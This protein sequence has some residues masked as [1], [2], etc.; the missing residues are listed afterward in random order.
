MSNEDNR[1]SRPPQTLR[2]QRLAASAAPDQAYSPA[3]CP[4]SPWCLP[5]QREGYGPASPPPWCSPR[6]KAPPSRAAA[7][8]FIIDRNRPSWG[9]EAGS[10]WACW[11]AGCLRCWVWG[12]FALL[13]ALGSRLARCWRCCRQ[14]R[15]LGPAQSRRRCCPSGWGTPRS[16]WLPQGATATLVRSNAFFDGTAR[17]P[18][19]S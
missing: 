18:R 12:V 14:T 16:S 5:A 11:P 15:L 1:T 3:C 8:V 13:A 10:S 9:V 4:R 19:S 6:E 7:H 2:E 17:T